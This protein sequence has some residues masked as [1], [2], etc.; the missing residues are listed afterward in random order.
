MY[1][2]PVRPSRRRDVLDA[3][4]PA[5]TA[6]P[7]P[8]T[9]API[10]WPGPLPRHLAVIMDGNG[11]WATARGLPR[12]EGHRQGAEVVRST[13][14]LA[15]R[16]GIQA[17]TLY[18][19]SEQNWQR[20]EGEVAA[21]MRLLYDFTQSERPE[22]L[23][24]GIRFRCVGDLERLPLPVQA[25]IAGLSDA[26]AHLTDMQLSIAVSY[27]GREEIVHAA[28]VLAEQAAAGHLDP[29]DIDAARL[30][31]ALW[32]RGLPGDVD[33][34]VRT[35][36]ERR[37][38]NFLLWQIA[39]AELHFTDVLWPDFSEEH[40]FEALRD[41]GR[42]ERRFGGVDPADGCPSDS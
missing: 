40:L 31:D 1:L 3:P 29:A 6:L 37:V 20:P 27:G 24:R 38:S 25:A 2:P 12:I 35:S 10:A 18:A 36:G 42:R 7:R 23:A 30:E 32:T 8:E 13:V 28:R 4:E 16:L 9:P 11:R 15:R 22:L 34:V 33:L 5:M 21:L 14:R 39:Y 26:T 17:L 41:F 19:F